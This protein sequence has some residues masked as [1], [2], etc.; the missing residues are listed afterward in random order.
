MLGVIWTMF[1]LATASW[2]TE[3]AL[4]VDK[5]KSPSVVAVNRHTV[6]AGNVVNAMVRVNVSQDVGRVTL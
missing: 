6:T 4:L 1:L 2:A 5:V 3:F